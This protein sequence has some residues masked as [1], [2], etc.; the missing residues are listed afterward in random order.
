MFTYLHIFVVFLLNP[1]QSPHLYCFPFKTTTTTTFSLLSFHYQ[2]HIS[3]VIPPLAPPQSDFCCFSITTSTTSFSLLSFHYQN[4]I[5][6]AIPPLAPPQ[7]DSCCFSIT[8]P[9]TSFRLS[10][11]HHQLILFSLVPSSTLRGWCRGHN[12]NVVVVVV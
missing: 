7:S 5:S 3:I 4:H 10:S 11:V 2:N 8:T 1:P 9:T 6:I 12:R